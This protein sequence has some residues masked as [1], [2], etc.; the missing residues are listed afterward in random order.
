MKTV[1]RRAFL[2]IVLTLAAVA[3]AQESTPTPAAPATQQ[4]S[5]TAENAIAAAQQGLVHQENEAA[6]E[7]EENKEF[8]ESPSVKW[9]ASHTGLSLGT[10]YW[11]LV[12]INFAIIAVLIAWAWKKNVPGMFRS[13]TES[14]RKNLDEARRA[15]EDANR[16]LGEI[17]SRLAKLDSEIAEIRKTSEAEAV[18]EEQRIKAAAEED[19]RKVIETAEQE[20]EAAAKAARRDLKAYAASLAVS[21]AEKKIQIDPKTDQSL[22]RTFVRELTQNGSKG[23][24]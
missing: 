5:A 21:I 14:I 4:N 19:R 17:E 16:R 12:C 20:I 2:V 11:V 1:I 18:A 24:R 10:A 3:F 13:R 9:F 6:G 22:V 15:S 23:G 7:G 8:K